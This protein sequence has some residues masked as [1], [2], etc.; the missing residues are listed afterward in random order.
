[1]ALKTKVKVGN[2]TNLSDARYCAGMGVDMLGFKISNI[3]GKGIGSLKF[4]EITDWISGPD[5]I[6]E[7][8]DVPNELLF[9]K[10]KVNLVELPASLISYLPSLRRKQNFILSLDLG[11]WKTHRQLLLSNRDRIKH[12]HITKVPVQQLNL[13]KSIVEEIASDFSVLIN[14]DS[15]VQFLEEILTWPVAGIALNGSEEASP[16]IKDYEHLSTILE[17]LEVD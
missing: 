9:E 13:V 3:E 6:V 10:Y 7:I 17:K 1:M 15:E 8:N 14:L 2:I 12:L 16:G 11:G 5:F 4:K